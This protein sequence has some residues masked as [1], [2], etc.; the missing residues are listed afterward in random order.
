MSSNMTTSDN[1]L[2]NV[3]DV[4]RNL[5][6]SVNLAPGGVTVGANENK[7][8]V[9]KF[10]EGMADTTLKVL[11]SNMAAVD[12]PYKIDENEKMEIV[13][14]DVL[15]VG[16]RIRVYY[17]EYVSGAW[18]NKTGIAIT[19]GLTAVKVEEVNEDDVIVGDANIMIPFRLRNE[20][21]NVNPVS[22]KGGAVGVLTLRTLGGAGDIYIKIQNGNN[23]SAVCVYVIP[24]GY[25]G[26]IHGVGRYSNDTTKKATFHY[27]AIPYG[28]P[29]QVARILT[30]RDDAKFE[31]FPVPY[32]FPEK[33]ILD[34]LGKVD[35][36]TALI[37]AYWD[38]TIIKT[39]LLD[40]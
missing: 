7:Y 35:V 33:T 30:L 16:Q 12:F 20:G 23:S 22:L 4:Y 38:M 18:V 15:D 31:I 6:K 32:K 29:R 28:M 1:K 26:F 37:G 39:E 40:S 27:A 2:V 24:T 8:P 36:G 11:Y 17:T 9:N 21:L 25:T 5:D 34:I 14:D 10:G 13:S 19:N 3:A